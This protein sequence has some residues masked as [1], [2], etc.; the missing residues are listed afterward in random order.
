MIELIDLKEIRHDGSDLSDLQ[1]MLKQLVGQP[2]LFFRVSYGDE[3]RFHLGDLQSDSNPRM[4]GRTKGSYIV[5]ARA[6]LWMVYSAPQHVLA[7]SDDDR[8]R[9]SET[10][11]VARWVDIKTIETG[12]F[13]TPGSI[14][15]SAGADHSAPGFSLRLHFSDGSTAY[16]RPAPDPDEVEPDGEEGSPDVGGLDIPDWEVLTTHQR[17]LKVGPGPRWS[18]LDSTRKRPA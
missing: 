2:F 8:A 12:G 15:T 13:I 1:A 18:Y 14:I 10:Q 17:I 5:G 3:L 16:T 4:R 11:A 9:P 7:T 6:S